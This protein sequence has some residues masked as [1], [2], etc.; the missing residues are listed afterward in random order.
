M[1]EAPQSIA[2]LGELLDATR[3]RCAAAHFGAYDYTA[4]CGFAPEHQHL[5][6]PACDFARSM[7]QAAYA[8]TGIRL[9]D[10]VTT[11]LPVGKDVAVVH[12]AWKVHYDNIRY[13]M[14]SGFY[15]SWDLHPAQLPARFAAV[16]AFH[17]EG[18]D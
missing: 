5:R 3:G 8:G 10:G 11:T 12:A 4:S 6:H 1:I 16:Y 18:L 17:L 14:A 13:S 9:S 7:M 2:I 15:Q